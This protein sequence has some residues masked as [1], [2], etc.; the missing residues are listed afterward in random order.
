MNNDD[1]DFLTMN[2]PMTRQ[3]VI[4]QAENVGMYHE[5]YYRRDQDITNIVDDDY[6]YSQPQTLI[7]KNVT[8]S[9]QINNPFGTPAQF[10]LIYVALKE[11]NDVLAFQADYTYN[12]SPNV[13]ANNFVPGQIYI[14]NIQ[15]PPA[16]Y[17]SDFQQYIGCYALAGTIGINAIMA[18]RRKKDQ[19]IPR[20]R[21]NF[22]DLSQ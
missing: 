12:L 11:L 15:P 17:W 3:P 2:N 6:E 10:V 1:Y 9:F 8:E 20:N 14:D 7:L 5:Q 19:I 18:F 16:L 22:N 4:K 13:S 21:T